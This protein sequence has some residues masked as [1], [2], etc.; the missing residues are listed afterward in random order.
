MNF[1]YPGPRKPTPQAVP[2]PGTR[3]ATALTTSRGGAYNTGIPEQDVEAKAHED[4]TAGVL[5]PAVVGVNSHPHAVEALVHGHEA[6]TGVISHDARGGLQKVDADL[7]KE[8]LRFKSSETAALEAN[9]DYE[10]AKRELILQERRMK[11][12]G[13]PI[14]SK[15]AAFIL[16]VAM[17]ALFGGDWSLITLGYQTL[18]LSDRPWLPGIAVT[19]DLHLAAFSSVFAL[20]ILGEAVGDRLRGIEYALENRRQAEEADRARLPRPARFDV[21]WLAVCLLGALGGVSALSYIRSEYL[22]ALGADTGGPAFFGIQLA[23]LLAAIAL[24]FAHAN[25]EAKRWKSNEKKARAAEA[26]RTAATAAVTESGSR[27]NAL[28]DQRDAL[29]AQTGHHISTDAANAELQASA[30]KRRYLLSQL[31]PVQERLFSEHKTPPQYNEKELLALI[32]GVKPIP[33]FEKVD[34]DTV[35]RAIGTTRTKLDRL[36]ARIDQVEINKLNLPELDED[37]HAPTQD[38]QKPESVAEETAE[39][40]PAATRL[41]PVRESA[42]AAEG[43]DDTDEET[44]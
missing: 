34:T 43:E 14:P 29:I 24:G 37:P 5:D 28:I 13:L 42:P 40:G 19:D 30:Y 44:A 12:T 33:A 15:K 35:I 1:K 7:E 8:R 39:E 18:G 11:A 10:S 6:A 3:P 38:G 20:V 32:T 4:G 21:F 31:E 23:I 41:R 26:A 22:K 17:I 2:F 27:I 9:S 36:R 25:P 16:A